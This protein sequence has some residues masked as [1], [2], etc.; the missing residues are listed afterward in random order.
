M[1]ELAQ[2]VLDNNLKCAAVEYANEIFDED[3]GKLMKYSQL[4]THLKYDE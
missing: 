2:A 1:E 3:L 4:I